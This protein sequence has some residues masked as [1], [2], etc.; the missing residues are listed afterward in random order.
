VGQ[1]GHTRQRDLQDQFGP[2]Y[3][4]IKG[5]AAEDRPNIFRYFSNVPV[6]IEVLTNDGL[7]ND[8]PILVRGAC[9]VIPGAHFRMEQRRK[10]KGVSERTLVGIGIRD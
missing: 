5:D 4:V 3:P 6:P 10:K 2:E 1:E 8:G 9:V 7:G